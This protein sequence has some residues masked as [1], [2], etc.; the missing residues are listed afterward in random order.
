MKIIIMTDLEG[1]AG[2]LN[3]KDYIHA[4]SRYY[5]QACELATLEVSAAAQGAFEAGATEVLVVDGHGPGAMKRA[6]LHPRARLLTGRPW[7][8]GYPWGCDGSFAAAMIVGQHSKANTD[9]GHLCH[10]GSFAVENEIVNDISVGEIGQWALITGYFGVPMVM[11]SGDEAACEEA[12]RL[13]PNIES[14]VVKWGVRRGSAT[15]LTAEENEVYNSVATHLSPDEA[16]GAI[17]ESAF[18]AVRRIPE[19]APFRLDPP[20]AITMTLRPAEAGRQVRVWNGEV[21]TTR[22]T[23]S[24]RAVRRPRS[25]P[26]TNEASQ[27][28]NPRR[29]ASLPERRRARRR[30][31]PRRKPRKSPRRSLPRKP[32]PKTAKKTVKKAAK[33]AVAAPAADKRP[34]VRAAKATAVATPAKKPGKTPAKKAAKRKR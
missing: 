28:P 7:I 23:L 12:R 26:G 29:R 9:G 21:P 34:A 32:R 20:Y 31:S 33:K 1:V 6:L 15:G 11:I 25:R 22:W 24:C 14:A 18:R 2:V 10:T 16:R 8:P 4:D 30:R 17:R 3:A 27:T 13:V 19:I 5:E